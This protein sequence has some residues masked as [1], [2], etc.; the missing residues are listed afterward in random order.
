[1]EWF[2]RHLAGPLAEARARRMYCL[3][4]YPVRGRDH[5]SFDY[6]EWFATRGG[7]LCH[8]ADRELEPYEH[9][10]GLGV[11]TDVV[12][13]SP[14]P[15]DAVLFDFPRSSSRDAADQFDATALGAARERLEG[16]RLIGSGPADSP[17]ADSFDEWIAYGTPHS[18]YVERA[19]RGVFAFVVGWIES[20]GLA[21]AEAQVAG[22]A[23]VSSPGELRQWMVCPSA[24]VQYDRAA[25][26]SLA[27]ALEEARERDPPRHRRRG[28]RQVRLRE[29]RR[30]GARSDGSLT[31][32]WRRTPSASVRARQ[33]RRPPTGARDPG[34]CDLL[35]APRRVMR[36]AQ[37]SEHAPH[38]P[39]GVEIAELS[40]ESIEGPEPLAD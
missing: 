6:C 16:C 28:R 14:Q 12:R 8:V 36:R 17:L 33:R 25:A 13:P 29:G 10:I 1:M 26:T 3:T 4:A 32:R 5:F 37:Q 7:V 39:P 20:M 23:V 11:D 35:K 38:R 15:R 18:V 2:E 30:A 27:A 22:A 9:W 21:V 31:L 34:K 19:F 24:G 40:A